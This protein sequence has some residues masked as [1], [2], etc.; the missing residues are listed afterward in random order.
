MEENTQGFKD[1]N[2]CYSEERDWSEV[3]MV[4]LI[5]LILLLLCF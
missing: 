1:R 3:L 2:I 4:Q 5:I